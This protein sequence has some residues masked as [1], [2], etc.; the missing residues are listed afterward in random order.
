MGDISREKSYIVACM[1]GKE[2]VLAGF[3]E[4]ILTFQ[5]GN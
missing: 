2:I 5:K 4:K 3:L 1:W